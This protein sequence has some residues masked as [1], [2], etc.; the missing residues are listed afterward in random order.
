MAWPLST[1]GTALA[2][3]IPT[4]EPVERGSGVRPSSA[5]ESNVDE[6]VRRIALRGFT[7]IWV[8]GVSLGFL[9]GGLLA[10]AI[11]G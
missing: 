8:A 11:A 10:W 9:A 1:V 3:H 4:V 6:L 5:P 7:L 2:S